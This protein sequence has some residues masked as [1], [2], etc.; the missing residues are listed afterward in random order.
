MT[1]TEK[2]KVADA[3]LENWV[4]QFLPKSIWPY[5]QL[6]RWDR[7]IGWKL[8]LWPC[9]WS[10]ALGSGFALKNEPTQLQILPLF[11]VWA[12]VFWLGAVAMRG[13][14]CTYNDIVDVDIDEAVARTASRPIP[15]GRVT[16]TK[17]AVFLGVQA[18]FGLGC[19]L[20]LSLLGLFGGNINSFA[21]ILGISSLAIVALYPFAKRIT[22]WPQL[23]LGL[24]FSWGALMGWA[25]IFGSLSP[26]P[27]LLYAGSI[28]WVIGYDTI[29]AHQDRE[30]DALVGVRS[31]ARLFGD[32]TKPAL[33]IL[34]FGT[35]FLFAAAFYQASAS[36]PAYIGLALGFS[37]MLRQI[38]R[39]EIED[40]DNCLALFKS[41]ST[42]GWIIFIGLVVAIF[43]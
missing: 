11:V 1:N 19:L 41:N 27:L 28:L 24:A 15:S 7:P 37:H 16:K 18:L 2:D 42:F 14:G 23:V 20:L 5:A 32:K 38:K 17:A 35:L 3:P 40:A 25:V 36:Y 9:L 12:I 39:L 43:I 13:A 29:Y 4:Y 6:A 10:L 8:L 21:I 22:D 31:T 33:I 34:Y 30:D 26:A